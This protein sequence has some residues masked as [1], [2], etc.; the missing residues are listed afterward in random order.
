M[1]SD[2]CKLFCFFEE[3]LVVNDFYG[4]FKGDSNEGH[5]KVFYGELTKN[6]QLSSNTYLIYLSEYCPCNVC[7]KSHYW[8]L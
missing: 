6:F 7:L 4:Y 2:D 8:K 5:N 3:I 1:R